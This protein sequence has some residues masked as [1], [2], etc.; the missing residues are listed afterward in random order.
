MLFRALTLRPLRRALGLAHFSASSTD[1]SDAPLLALVKPSSHGSMTFDG[2]HVDALPDGAS[3]AAHFLSESLP[4]WRASGVSAV[5]AHVEL[6]G[7]AAFLSLLTAPVA[8]GGLGFSLH[9]ARGTSAALVRWI[10]DGPSRVPPYAGTQI[11]V[12]GVV[13]DARGRLLLVKEARGGG[14]S[15]TPTA[16]ASVAATAAAT[17]VTASSTASTST[18]ASASA[19]SAAP[20]DGP[21]SAAAAAF[22]GWKYPGGR[23]DTGEDLGD[24]AVREVW[25]ETGVRT[26]FLSLLG[27]RHSHTAPWGTDD[28]YF[29]AALEPLAGS[30]GV[31]SDG[32]GDEPL[33]TQRDPVEIAEVQWSEA[34]AFASSATHPF[35]RFADIALRARE[36]PH[37]LGGGGGLDIAAQ[38]VY[39]PSLQRWAHVY[40]P[41]AL[42]EGE[43]SPPSMKRAPWEVAR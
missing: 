7:G 25:E 31:P 42:G 29:L 34:S 18:A 20:G 40:A 12:G 37:G 8:A 22:Q 16:A 21:L 38:K 14:G 17:V 19:I 39:V 10:G 32:G 24:A 41:A 43:M 6:P 30:D 13:I 3:R 1:V 35:A 5:W 33:P 4:R 15:S 28:V 2:S 23:A 27:L 26:R 36:S 9:H 11:G